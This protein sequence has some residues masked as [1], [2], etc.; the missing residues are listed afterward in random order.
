MR[1]SELA[2]R[3]GATRRVGIRF[4]RRQDTMTAAMNVL[5]DLGIDV[6]IEDTA[7]WVD[8]PRP[9][10]LPLQ[11]ILERATGTRGFSDWDHG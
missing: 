9:V 5:R 3:P 10:A 6:H 1:A 4:E 7:I 11:Q 8:A 2:G